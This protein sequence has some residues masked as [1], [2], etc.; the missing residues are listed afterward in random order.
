MSERTAKGPATA[1][2][3]TRAQ[4]AA[5]RRAAESRA[6]VP[7]AAWTLEAGFDAVPDPVDGPLLAAVA[8]A[9]R[10]FPRLN[11]TYRDGRVDAHERVNLGVAVTG[12]DWTLVPTLVD[13]DARDGATLAAEL[14]SLRAAATAGE[15]TA[16]ALAAATFTVAG[17]GLDAVRQVVPVIVPGQVA[18]LGVGA[19]QDR[20]VVD[21]DGRLAVGRRA[22]LVLV[23]DVRAAQGDEPA[24][25]LARVAALLA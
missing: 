10:E 16:A 1:H 23:A 6:T 17:L 7:D 20:P 22:D 18:A 9:L 5:G 11:A 8:A 15:L 19:V 14:E 25:F 3:L 24:R 12:E 13:A 2:E 4:Q 21:A